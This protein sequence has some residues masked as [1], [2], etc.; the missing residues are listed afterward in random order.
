MQV[1]EQQFQ[2]LPNYLYYT[3]EEPNEEIVPE[4]VSINFQMEFQKTNFMNLLVRFSKDEDLEVRSFVT[5][6]NFVKTSEVQNQILKN[7]FPN[8]EIKIPSL[9]IF[10]KMR[11][12][13]KQCL[14]SAFLQINEE[15]LLDFLKLNTQNFELLH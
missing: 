9:M 6:W 4:E 11:E 5:E 13:Y 14:L 8:L 3:F 1:L 7:E 2:R 10:R 15:F 12:L